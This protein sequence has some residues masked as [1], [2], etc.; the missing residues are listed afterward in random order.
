MKKYILKD[1]LCLPEH[2]ITENIF[3]FYNPYKRF[4][5]YSILE[6]KSKCLFKGCM[7]QLNSYCIY[8]KNKNII[9]FRKDALLSTF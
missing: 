4:Y 9:S 8:D 5:D 2:I 6:L 7:R 3:S 1:I